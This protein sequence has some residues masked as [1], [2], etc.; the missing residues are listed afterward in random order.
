MVEVKRVALDGD[1]YAYAC[2]RILS[3]LFV[4]EGLR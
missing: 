3:D 4:A 2:Y 1:A